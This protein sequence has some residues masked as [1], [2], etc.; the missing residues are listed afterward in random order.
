MNHRKLFTDAEEMF[1]LVA[2]ENSKNDNIP[3]NIMKLHG[4]RNIYDYYKYSENV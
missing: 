1:F 3:A 4:A 2:A